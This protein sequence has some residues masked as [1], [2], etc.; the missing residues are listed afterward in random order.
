MADLEEYNALTATLSA[1][2]N[3]HK[4]EYEE[5]VKP[6]KLKWASLHDLDKRL[7]PWYE[8]HTRDMEM[9]ISMNE[10]FCRQLTTAV[11][12][13]WGI[14]PDASTWAPASS[15]DFDKVRSTLL[16]LSR[17]WSSDG[18]EER[19][20]SVGRIVA[21]ITALFPDVE[22][23]QHRKILVPGCGLG[24]L[25]IELV[26]E[27]FWTQGNEFSY[28]MLL[29]SNFILNHCK[30][31]N[32]YSVFPFLHKASHLAKRSNHIRPITVPDIDPLEI[33]ELMKKNP[34]I[35][36]DELM[37][38]TAGS[39]VDLYGP[40]GLSFSS[41]YSNDP[42][43]VEF[44]QQNKELFDVVA[45]SFFI[46]TA[47]NVIDYLRCIHHCLKPGGR[48]INFGPLLWHFEDFGDV[49]LVDKQ[50]S[51]DGP[52]ERVPNVLR[53]LELSLEDLV[54]LIEEVGFKFEKRESGIRSTYSSD[55][56]AL[57]EFVYKCEYWV[58][59][60]Q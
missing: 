9:C 18:Q 22:A 29:A 44:R 40:P 1:Y 12:Q 41:T 7:L 53:G 2:S 35:P 36:Y 58:V 3:F 39:F 26:R 24:R 28:H 11:A 56:R 55:V 27:G 51:A 50:L 43:A 38:M 25:V 17:E 57:G 13:E 19:D 45:T 16:Q 4:W 37:S 34:K 15:S 60:K 6:R 31:P 8:K 52:L 54:S 23:R 21:E 20:K 49:H 47:S 5:F 42:T 48:W 46:D 33:H 10:E 14:S 30:F 59:V 32:S